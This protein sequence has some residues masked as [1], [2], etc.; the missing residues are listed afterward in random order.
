MTTGSIIAYLLQS[1][2]YL[3]AGYAAYK[4]LLSRIKMP[5]FNRAVIIAIYTAAF[6]VPAMP[7][8]SKMINDYESQPTADA[9]VASP[10]DMAPT[11]QNIKPDDET[12]PLL[13]VAPIETL[14]DTTSEA[15]PAPS[16]LIGP[17]VVRI[18]GAAALAVG[19]VIL[20][21]LVYG[22]LSV[23]RMRRN[24]E[25]IRTGNIRIVLVDDDRISPFSLI[26]HIFMSRRDYLEGNKM[27]VDHE[28]GHIRHLHCIDLMISKICTALMWWNPTCWL[29]N[30]ELRAVHEYQADE[31]VLRTGHDMKAYQL[32]LIQKAAGSN[33]PVVANSLNH[34]KLKNRFTMMYLNSPTRWAALRAIAIIPAF[35]G[36]AMLVHQ[37]S[38]ASAIDKIAEI[39]IADE[40]VAYGAQNDTPLPSSEP[41]YIS[42]RMPQQDANIPV[43]LPEMAIAD[44]PHEPKTAEKDASPAPLDASG[45]SVWSLKVLKSNPT[46][47][48][49]QLFDEQQQS[50]TINGVPVTFEQMEEY[51]R[52]TGNASFIKRLHEKRRIAENRKRD[53]ADKRERFVRVDDDESIITVIN[54]GPNQTVVIS[55]REQGKQT[56]SSILEARAQAMETRAQ[57]AKN[58]EAAAKARKNAEKLREKA[59]HERKRNKDKHNRSPE[60]NTLE[61]TEGSFNSLEG[62]NLE[63]LQQLKSLENLDKEL[64]KLDQAFEKAEKQFQQIEKAFDNADFSSMQIISNDDE[65][66]DAPAPEQLSVCFISLDNTSGTNVQIMIASK[67]PLNIG[68]ATMVV[69]GK[70]YK[71]TTKTIAQ[72]YQGQENRYQTLVKIHAR[73][74]TK[75]TKNDYVSVITDRGTV[76]VSLETS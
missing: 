3:A 9:H 69:N 22:M 26:N 53:E 20:L 44:A 55:P 16:I 52:D 25:C 50:P 54:D 7:P 27:I 8:S 34:S 60:L 5:A 1:A 6:I 40:G 36:V 65:E 30:H 48:N 67:R 28:L 24:G 71:C 51:L 68:S 47:I 19:C 32:L 18:L 42:I 21:Q 59:A 61:F 63:G 49:I 37:N 43:A 10:L 70:R 39:T 13:T 35:C 41:V 2:L 66:E 73:K 14:T 58:R 33:I 31:N 76:K 38:F 74:L 56:S 15:A 46:H 64:S 12:T 29:L 11:H 75:F 4:L 72:I 45:E 62:L 57:A 17:H 23:I